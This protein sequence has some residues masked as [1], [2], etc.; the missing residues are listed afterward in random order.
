MAAKPH[1]NLVTVGHVDQ[2][3][4]TLVGRLLYDTGNVP[5]E[6]MRKLKE[7]ATEFKKETFEAEF[8][9]IPES[10]I[11]DATK[12]VTDGEL[13]DQDF[14]KEILVGWKSVNDEDGNAVEYSENT[15]SKLLDFPLV[16]RA[17]VLAFFESLTGA[18]RKNS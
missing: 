12:Q 13:T 17:L 16:S 18:K 15:K 6:E 1:L 2:G 10:R 9:R 4:S 5:E 7:L 14:A 8:K 3:K 11:K